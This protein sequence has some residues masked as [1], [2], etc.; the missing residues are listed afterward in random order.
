MRD[1]LL[2]EN[3][4]KIRK[5]TKYLRGRLLDEGC[6][7]KYVNSLSDQQILADFR[8]CADCG[9]ELYT[10]DQQLHIVLEFDTPERA[11][12]ILYDEIESEETEEK[13]TE[14]YGLVLDLEEEEEEEIIRGK[15]ILDGA[16]S[17]QNAI[18]LIDSFK[19]YLETLRDEGYE[20]T[21]PIEDDYGYLRKNEQT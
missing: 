16:A 11:F 17:I 12:S 9:D 5:F 14:D 7:Q 2:E 15:W 1:N 8:V 13:E 3:K 18:E 10:V 19:A 6:H 4:N 21:H 20:L